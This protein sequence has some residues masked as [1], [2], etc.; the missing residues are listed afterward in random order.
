MGAEI[1]KSVNLDGYDDRYPG[2]LSGGEKQRLAIARALASK[3]AY[4]L[5]D[6]P[7]SNL[8]IILIEELEKFILE[9]KKTTRIGIIYVS[10]RIEEVLM[11]ADRI[12]IMDK[13]KLIQVDHKHNILQNPNSEFVRRFLKI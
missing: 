3:P 12:A 11:V 1:L 13:G 7:F 4:L 2:Q 5:M 8:D 6:E 10:H 9:L